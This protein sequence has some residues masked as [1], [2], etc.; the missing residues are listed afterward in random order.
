L[1]FGKFDLS[2]VFARR[3]RG[4]LFDFLIFLLNVALFGTLSARLQELID[5]A[6]TEDY[7]AKLGMAVYVFSLCILPGF[8][9]VLKFFF[10]H[11]RS[12]GDYEELWGGMFKNALAVVLIGHVLA[13]SF[14][15]LWAPAFTAN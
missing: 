7:Y 1:R 2:S 3:N 6:K 13:L 4:I 9:A 5:L 15:S 11:R 10:G 12:P 14:S 8:A